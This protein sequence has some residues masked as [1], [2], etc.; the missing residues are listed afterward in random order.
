MLRK[1]GFLALGFSMMALPAL[2]SDP[3]GSISGYV[4]SS[5]GV[6][7]MGAVVELLGSSAHN[8]RVFTD[9][10][11]FYSVRDLLPGSYSLKVTAPAFLPPLRGPADDDDWKWT[12]RSAANRP[13]LRVLADGSPVTA[14]KHNVELGGDH[15]LKAS[16]SFLAGSP[17]EGY[18]A[19]SDMSTGFLVEHRV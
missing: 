4:R 11:G 16:L 5:A 9:D 12:L 10:H 2:A 14:V 19:I 13:V 8:L 18:G 17:S 6:P 7:Q 1:L 15:D 3:P